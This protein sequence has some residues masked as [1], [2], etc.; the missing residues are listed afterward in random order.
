VFGGGSSL[1]VGIGNRRDVDVK[2]IE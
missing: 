2:E 1:R